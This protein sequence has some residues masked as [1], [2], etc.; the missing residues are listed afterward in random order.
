MTIRVLAGVRVVGCNPSE[1]HVNRQV[2]L[3]HGQEGLR[4]L[5]CQPGPHRKG[6]YHREVGERSPQHLL[7]LLGASPL[8]LSP[9]KPNFQPGITEL[10][11]P[12][13]GY[14]GGPPPTS[15]RQ[16]VPIVSVPVREEQVC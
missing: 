8:S 10:P 7:T 1:K 13:P 5:S 3:Q 4:C 6:C 12:A 16:P 14:P 9:S 15:L 11:Y 2:L